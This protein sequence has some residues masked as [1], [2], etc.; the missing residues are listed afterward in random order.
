LANALLPSA[1]DQQQRRASGPAQ[2]P[3]RESGDAR[4][5]FDQIL[6]E[7]LLTLLCLVLAAVTVALALIYTLEPSSQVLVAPPAAASARPASVSPPPAVRDVVPS[8]P[9]APM[10][11]PDRSFSAAGPGMA[12]PSAAAPGAGVRSASPAATA[13]GAGP[14]H[15]D[16]NPAG[17]Q[18]SGLA[19]VPSGEGDGT[20]FELQDPLEGQPQNDPAGTTY[21][22]ARY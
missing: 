13:A 1:S 5:S 20:G 12:G 11:A 18:P 6:V 4:A 8:L 2:A 15:P 3:A 16:R 7:W 10:G 22:A 14:R 19:A 9:P 21:P 17:A